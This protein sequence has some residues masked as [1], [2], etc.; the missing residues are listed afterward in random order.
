MMVRFIRSLTIGP[1]MVRR[2][3]FARESVGEPVFDVVCL[4]GHIDAHLTRPGGITVA[5][6]LGELDAIVLHDCVD[7][8]RHGFHQVL[9]ELP[10]CPLISLFDECRRTGTV[11][12]PQS[13]PQRYQRGRSWWDSVSSAGVAAYRPRCPAGGRCSA[14]CVR[15]RLDGYRVQRQSSSGSSV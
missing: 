4:A 10:C 7:A 13:A 14:D 1:R 8:V 9:E 2:L 15:C 3:G 11:C 6:L 5:Q 12:L